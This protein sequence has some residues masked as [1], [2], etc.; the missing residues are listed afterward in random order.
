MAGIQVRREASG[1]GWPAG[2]KGSHSR[3][4]A[5]VAGGGGRGGG[6]G[7][8][9]PRRGLARVALADVGHE[10]APGDNK[11]DRHRRATFVLNKLYHSKFSS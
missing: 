8:G 1:A 4:A 9:R 7:G 2:Y 3:P 11:P 6:G 5:R 10:V